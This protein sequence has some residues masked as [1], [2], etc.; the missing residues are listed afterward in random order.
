MITGCRDVAKKD[1]LSPDLTPQDMKNLVTPLDEPAPA[2]RPLKAKNKFDD[3]PAAFLQP[4]SVNLSEATPLK[5]VL[6]ELARQANI[7]LQL[8]PKIDKKIVFTAKNKPFIQV[9]ENICEIAGLRYKIVDHSLRIEADLA[10]VENYNVQFLN[11]ARSSENRISIATDV[12]A[13]SAN[14]AGKNPQDNGSNSAVTIAGNNDFW[15]EL[16]NNLKV[17][18]SQTPNAT[19]PGTYSIHRQGGIVSVSGSSKHHQL[20]KNYLNTLRQAASSQVLIEAKI[21]EV[22]LKDEFRSGINWQKVSARNDVRVSAPFGNLAN[23]HFLDPGISHSGVVSFGGA[24]KTFSIILEALQEFGSSRTLSSPRLTVMNNQTAILKVARNQ[25]YF[26]LHYDKQYNTAVQRESISVSSDIQTVPIGFVMSVQPSIDPE[27]GEI[28]LFLRPTVS[29]LNRSVRD[30]AVD[31]INNS[32]SR[33]G[34]PVRP[35]LIPVV[36]VREIDSIL[37]VKDGGVAILGG[38]MEVRSVHDTNKLPIVGDVDLLKELF[39]SYAVGDQVVEL[40][41]LLRATI[42][43][44]TPFGPDAADHR[45]QGY[46]SDPRPLI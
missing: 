28:I 46:I 45:V 23:S 35:S 10:Y 42:M 9:I 24:G 22:V 21:I 12:F 17:I 34:E 41:I 37:R 30:P 11:L 7:D 38:L 43:P 3:I 4:V 40:V 39:S 36:E 15:N 6:I 33:T 13:D 44:D 8:D 5:P 20:V 25:V 1:S 14:P 16:E 27:T 19:A 32:I 26:R 31:I 2:L 29:R 18:L